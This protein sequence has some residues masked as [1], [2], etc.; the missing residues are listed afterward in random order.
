TPLA[1]RKINT[2][3]TITLT[4][5]DTNNYYSSSINYTIG[6]PEK[7]KVPIPTS[8][9]YCKQNLFYNQTT[10]NLVNL[11]PNGYKFINTTAT[12]I[13][14]YTVTAKL[15]Y[16]YIWQEDNSIEDKTIV[17]EI[18]RPTPLVT[19]DNQNGT[20]CTNKTVTYE[21]EYGE[22]CTPTRNGYKFTG[23]YTQASNGDN[24]TSNTKVTNFNN[25]TLYAHWQENSGWGNNG[26][27]KY[28]L[29]NGIKVTGWKKI[30]NNWYYFAKAD[31]KE[32]KW[33]SAKEQG[34]M[35]TGW[36]YSE[37]YNCPTHGWYFDSNGI[38]L[39]NTTVNE[40][41][42][43][44]SGCW[45]NYKKATTTDIWN[46]Y[47]NPGYVFNVGFTKITYY[48]NSST[49]TTEII[50]QGTTRYNNTIASEYVGTIAKDKTV[51]VEVDS[52]NYP[53]TYTQLSNK[54]RTFIGIYVSNNNITINNNGC[55]LSSLPTQ[56]INET[57][58]YNVWIAA[59]CKDNGV[60]CSKDQV[61]I[62][63]Q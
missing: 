24:I 11:A 18:K 55:G 53:V 43:D 54:Y 40:Y 29:E 42:L 4:P 34:C 33:Q 7:T 32:N 57:T 50:N 19:Y 63:F 1:T 22:L 58:Y 39:S 47:K 14:S 49:A 48:P 3:I 16:G 51:Y 56:N 59:E 10:Q 36:V 41:I 30:G 45:R 28:Y 23:W 46:I 5:T 2:T 15:Q 12:N 60:T 38:M 25:H 61:S 17:C 44:S 6:S 62:K 37:D 52:N 26:T 31:G 9:T 8:A 13:G 35:Y 20:G 27:C 21:S